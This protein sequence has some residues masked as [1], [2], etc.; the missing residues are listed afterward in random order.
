ME[1]PELERRLKAIVAADVEGYSPLMHGDE[2]G[3]MAAI[4]AR[5]AILD[6]LVVSHR[7]RTANTAGDSVLDEFASVLDAVICAVEIQRALAQLNEVDA[8]RTMQFRIG[9]NVGDVMVK[10]GDIF[11]DGV[12]VAARLESLAEGGGICVSRGVRDHL[13]YRTNFIFEDLGEQLV[14]ILPIPSGLSGCGSAMPTQRSCWTTRRGL[15]PSSA[16]QKITK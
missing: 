13:R 5:R 6:E 7:G 14:K 15:A 4:A 12:N 11:G 2:E 16:R 8:E 9:I 10:D 1:A 3:S